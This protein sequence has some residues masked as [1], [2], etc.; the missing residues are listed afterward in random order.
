M[1][2]ER[3]SKGCKEELRGWETSTSQRIL[4]KVKERNSA[5]HRG[6]A[7][8]CSAASLGCRAAPAR[9]SLLLGIVSKKLY[10]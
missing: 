5:R 7:G 3:A 1:G 2:L 6:M 9:P 10:S 4:L 8:M